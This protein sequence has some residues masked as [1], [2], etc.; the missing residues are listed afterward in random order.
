MQDEKK[1]VIREVEIG[2][3]PVGQLYTE[4]EFLKSIDQIGRQNQGRG[5]KRS[6][7]VKYIK[8]SLESGSQI[9]VNRATQLLGVSRC[10]F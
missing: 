8:E 1:S 7:G 6:T 4:N 5:G 3:K 10:G 2:K 9:S